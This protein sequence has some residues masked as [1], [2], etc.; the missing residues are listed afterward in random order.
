[1]CHCAWCHSVGCRSHR[2]PCQCVKFMSSVS[3]FLFWSARARVCVW[4]REREREEDGRRG[5][6][7]EVA[8]VYDSHSE[9]VHHSMCQCVCVCVAGWVCMRA[10]AYLLASLCVSVC[11]CP[12]VS[13][14]GLVYIS[15]RLQILGCADQ[16][17]TCWIAWTRTHSRKA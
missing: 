15:D 2:G 5:W 12:C 4:E 7:R 3:L 13:V 11:L 10:H 6:G 14:F 1:M 8:C 9:C 17:V 16:R